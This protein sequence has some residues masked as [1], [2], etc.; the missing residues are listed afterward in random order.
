MII[1]TKN[2]FC[3]GLDIIEHNKLLKIDFAVHRAVNVAKASVIDCVLLL[4][5]W[6]YFFTS[7][8]ILRVM[9]VRFDGKSGFFYV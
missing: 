7:D 1:V 3:G 6:I 4:H 5:F 2:A 9:R 8:H